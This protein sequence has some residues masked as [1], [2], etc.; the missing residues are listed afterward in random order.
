MASAIATNSLRQHVD[1]DEDEARISTG[2][3]HHEEG[4]RTQS[5]MEYWKKSERPTSLSWLDANGIG[6]A[7]VF[8]D[9][10]ELLEVEVRV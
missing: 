5:M 6:W 10:V 3:P 2:Q 4:P 8:L 1:W 7:S 9:V